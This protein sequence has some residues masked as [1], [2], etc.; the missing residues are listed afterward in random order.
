MSKKDVDWLNIKYKKI[1]CQTLECPIIAYWENIVNQ[2][3]LEKKKKKKRIPAQIYLCP[4]VGNLT[5]ACHNAFNIK[6]G[7]RCFT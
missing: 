3:N 2:A 1:V 6:Y 5:T 7:V 4:Q